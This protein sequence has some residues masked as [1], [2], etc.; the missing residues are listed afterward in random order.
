MICATS[1]GMYGCPPGAFMMVPFPC[2]VDQNGQFIQ[3]P[4]NMDQSQPVSWPLSN[5]KFHMPSLTENDSNQEQADPGEP[6][7][8]ASHISERMYLVPN[9]NEDEKRDSQTEAP[10]LN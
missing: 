10:K 2:M 7:K 6:S 9:T 1:A 3:F 4:C 8:D 5:N